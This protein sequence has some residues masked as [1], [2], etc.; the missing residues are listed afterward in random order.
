MD[1]QHLAPSA[2]DI[3]PKLVIQVRNDV[4]EAA[5]EGFVQAVTNL[6][7]NATE[8]HATACVHEICRIFPRP[9]TRC[10]RHLHP[11]APRR[12]GASTCV[13]GREP[14]AC[15]TCTRA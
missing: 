11:T 12:R 10:R 15:D 2:L 14:A 8:A 13:D 1:L 4:L 3:V 9:T 7:T 5:K 6:P